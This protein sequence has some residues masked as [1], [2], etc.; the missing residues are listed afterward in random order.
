MALGLLPVPLPMQGSFT[1]QSDSASSGFFSIP[2]PEEAKGKLEELFLSEAIFLHP[3]QTYH[4]IICPAIATWLPPPSGSAC[5]S[6]L[7]ISQLRWWQLCVHW[8]CL[9]ALHPFFLWSGR[10]RNGVG[11]LMFLNT[12]CMRNNF[13]FSYR[14]QSQLKS[15]RFLLMTYSFYFYSFFLFF[16]CPLKDLCHPLWKPASLS[17]GKTCTCEIY[18]CRVCWDLYCTHK[19]FLLLAQW[20]PETSVNTRLAYQLAL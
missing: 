4:D 8:L 13:N 10:C 2:H 20:I 19:I 18:A 17:Q 11:M 6:H 15:L 12:L 16:W 3:E 5:L 1:A 9:S 7:L 14:S